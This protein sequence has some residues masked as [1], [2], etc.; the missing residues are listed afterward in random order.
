MGE[1]GITHARKFDENSELAMSSL[2]WALSELESY[3]VARIVT[4]DG[5][6]PALVLLAPHI[7]PDFECLYDIP[8]PFAEDVRQYQFPPLDKVITVTGK[9]VLEHRLLPKDELTEAM[10]DYVDSM[11]L[12]AYGIDDEGNPAEFAPPD[13]TFNPSIH[14]INNAVKHRAV[15]PDQSVPDI[16]SVLLRFASPPE[17]LVQRV[18]SRIDTLIQTAKIEKVPPKA[19]GRYKREPIKPISG[20][21]VDALLEVESKGKVSP[22]NAVPDFKR[23]LAATEQVSE[24]QDATKQMGTIIRSLIS[25]SFANSKYDQAIEALGAMR[26]ELINFEEPGMYNTFVRDLKKSLLSGALGGDRREFWYKVRLLK[27][28]LIDQAHSEV[29]NV[30]TADAEEF[31]KSK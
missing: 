26:E 8:L 1:V 9:T 5:K 25:A 24:I 22:E 27:L 31:Y 13:E 18:Q 19:K 12:S 4:K 30:S 20:L 10:S 3:A 17:D 6:D 11:D 7:E 23:A 14:R 28:G 2:V 21:D 29:S 15:H 16:P